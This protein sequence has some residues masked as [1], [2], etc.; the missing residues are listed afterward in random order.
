M[1]VQI[2]LQLKPLRNSCC[3]KNNNMKKFILSLVI[4]F[5]GILS[6]SAQYNVNGHRFF[7]NWSVGVNGGVQTNLHDWNA[8]QGAVTGLTFN[9]QV[10]PVFGLTFEGQVG[11]NNLANWNHDGYSHLMFMD[12]N[13]LPVYNVAAPLNHVHNGNAVDAVG[14]YALGNV[15]LMNWFAGYKGSPRLFEVVPFAGVGYGHTFFNST[16][17]DDVNHLLAKAGTSLDFNL[18]KERAWSINLRPAVVYN[19]AQG[20]AGNHAYGLKMQHAVFEATAGVTYHFRTSN[21]KHHFEPVPVPAPVE[22]IREVPVEVPVEV[23]KEVPVEVV[24]NVATGAPEKVIIGFAFDSAELTNYAMEALDNLAKNHKKATVVA[25]ASYE[26]KT[27]ATYN[28]NLSEKRAK[29]VADYLRER[30][31]DVEACEGLGSVNKESNRIAIVV[32]K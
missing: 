22:I 10:T 28:M 14:V 21:G 31:V 32:A 9:K 11:W 25:Y 5:V 12:A 30:G 13:Q 19:V 27:P 20:A 3:P 15:N 16:Y 4:A 29:V 24:K 18:G 8:P 7:D 6:A 17:G 1:N 26:D 2:N 23:V